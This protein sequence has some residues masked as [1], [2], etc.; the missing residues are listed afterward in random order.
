VH[1][2]R[3]YRN[4]WQ[5]E[6]FA[7]FFTSPSGRDWTVQLLEVPSDVAVQT[8]NGPHPGR[9]VLRF[10]SHDITL[11]LADIPANWGDCTDGELVALLRVA[12]TPAFTPVVRRRDAERRA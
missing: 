5:P 4:A 3:E 12:T 7:R 11:D 9:R 1:H 2:S 6:A 10:T 8:I